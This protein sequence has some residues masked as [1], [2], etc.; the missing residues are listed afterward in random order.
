[1]DPRSPFA[2]FAKSEQIPHTTKVHVNYCVVCHHVWKAPAAASQCINC[3]NENTACSL[4]NY[5]TEVG[6]L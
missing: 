4:V 3:T 5:D 1:M 2:A 6:Q